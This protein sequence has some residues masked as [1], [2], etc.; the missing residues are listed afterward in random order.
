MQQG[1]SDGDALLLAAGELVRVFVE[2]CSEAEA[3]DQ[4]GLESGI[5]PAA[6]RGLE[7][8]VV[9][10]AER[11]DEVKL[12]KHQT[13]RAAPQR[14][15]CA[16]VQRGQRLPAHRDTASVRRIEPGGQVQQRAFAAAALAQ[17]SHRLAGGDA[18][19]HPAQHG[20]LALGLG[21]AFDDAAETQH[22][23]LIAA[24]VAGETRRP[25]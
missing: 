14:R 12:L 4:L 16:I 17:Q 2:L 25:A 22:A 24:G 6:Q 21:I 13:D 11:A 1:A 9:G 8:D 23:R 7:A 19:I 18:Q 20:D 5:E 15:Q 3:V 10:H